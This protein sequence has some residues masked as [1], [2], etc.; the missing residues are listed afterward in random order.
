[1][2]VPLWHLPPG[3]LL[4]VDIGA[5]A[6]V[7]SVTGYAVHRLAVHRLDHDTWLSRARRFERGGRLYRDTLHINRW[8]D[9]LPE[10]GGLFPGGVSKRHLPPA[11][12]GGL[13][14][15]SV[16]TRRAELGHWLAA[17]GGP[18]FALW[19]PAPVAVV[20]V[21]YGVGVNLPFV[22]IQRY[23]RL[24]ITRVLRR[25]NG[26]RGAA[27]ARAR[28]DRGTNGASMPNGSPPKR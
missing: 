6:V 21:V 4:L 28:S 22:A 18:V 27:W 24:R 17:A 7:H 19:N 14:R 2:S 10:A 8:K 15:F 5:W 16:E 23:N 13:E 26:S 9:A 12:R 3:P 11:D 20:M 1:V 25:P